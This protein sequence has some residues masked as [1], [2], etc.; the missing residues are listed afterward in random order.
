MAY[1][2]GSNAGPREPRTVEDYLTR[3]GLRQCNDSGLPVQIHTGFGWSSGT[4]LHLD[5]A[6]VSN[7]IPLFE[8]PEFRKV[9]FLIFHGSWPNTGTMGYLAASYENVYLDFNCLVALSREVAARS[10]SEWLD[11]VPLQKLMTGTDG[12]YLEWW[13]ATARETR[14]VLTEVLSRKVYQGLYSETM[15]LDAAKAVLQTNAREA[16]GL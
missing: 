4:P 1:N 5:N 12:P 16:L 13:I 6:D 7:L 10:L 3:H 9:R 15:A 11:I 8:A 14:R 2:Q